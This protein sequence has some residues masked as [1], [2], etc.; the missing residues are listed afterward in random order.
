M[1]NYYLPTL[2]V[3]DDNAVLN[4][5]QKS[6]DVCCKRLSKL[7]SVNTKQP[8]L[9]TISVGDTKK[10]IEFTKSDNIRKVMN[11][12]EILLQ[13]KDMVQSINK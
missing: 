3:I 13:L 11:E 1:N 10:V 9:I 5:I 2:S 12:L 7:E 4:N 6:I 8:H